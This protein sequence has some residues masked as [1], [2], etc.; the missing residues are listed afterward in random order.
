MNGRLE[1]EGG[2]A[3]F[4]RR[5]ARRLLRQMVQ[6]P[7]KEPF[8]HLRGTLPVGVGKAVAT[9][10]GGPANAGERPGAQL[11]RVAQ[12]VEPDAVG[13]LSIQQTDR[14]APRTETA[15]LIRYTRLPR[16]F[17]DLVLRN[18]I[19]NLAQNVKP[20]PCWFDSFVFHACRVAGSN[21][22]ANTFFRFPVRWL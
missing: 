10:C 7:P 18:E 15:R 12:I 8:R 21:R 14:V 2:A 11:Q 4:S 22:H 13:E 17:R 19:A 20:G 16:Y 6:S 9:G 5:K 3:P 1:T